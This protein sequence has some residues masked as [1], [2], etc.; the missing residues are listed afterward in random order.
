[1]AAFL[2]SFLHFAVLY[3][4]R[5]PIT[6]RQTFTA[7]FA[8]MSVQWTVARAVA[9]GLIKDHLPFTRTAKGGLTAFSRD[10]QAFWEAVIGGLL[11]LS[12]I[13]LLWTNTKEV[14]EINIYAAVLLLQS[15]PFV[16]AALLAAIEGTRANDF[17]YWRSLEAKLLVPLPKRAAA[18]AEVAKASAPAAVDKQPETIQ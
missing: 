5:V 1:V 2:V 15:L 16:S 8:A 7:V 11:V 17:A 4:L 13:V 9:D 6:L 18:I 12:A 10:Y 14:R 3:R